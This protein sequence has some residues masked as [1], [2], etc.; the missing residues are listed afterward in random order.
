MSDEK[1]SS[2]FSW[3]LAGLGLGALLGVL[4]APKAGRE[5]REELASSAREGTEYLKQ[6]SRETADQVSVYVDRGK[7]QVDTLRKTKTETNARRVLSGGRI[8]MVAA[9]LLRSGD[10]VTVEA[11]E[12]IPGDGDVIEGIASVDESAITERAL[13]SFANPAAIAAP[14]PAAP[15]CSAIG[16]RCASPPTPAKPSWTA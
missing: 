4:Y 16:S 11:G 2:G 1:Q 8:E 10:I 5:T 14:L 6:K 13:R 3:F 9:A 7:A 15:R 12:T